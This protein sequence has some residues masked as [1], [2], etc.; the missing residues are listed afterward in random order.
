MSNNRFGAVAQY[1]CKDGY[2][3]HGD[4]ARVCQGDET[5]SGSIPQCIVAHNV[6]KELC[7]PP[8]EVPHATHDGPPGQK[9]FVL[10]TWLQY[11]CEPD[12]VLSNDKVLRAWCVGGV[13]PAWV[14]PNITCTRNRA[15]CF[16]PP[17]IAHASHDS[18]PQQQQFSSGHRLLYT[19]FYGFYA[20]GQIYAVCND[21]GEW[22]GPSMICLPS[23]CPRLFAPLHGRMY[24]DGTDYG[25]VIR[26]HCDTGYKNVGSFERR[27]LADRTWSGQHAR[28]EEMSCAWPGP[29]HNGYLD[30][31]KTTVG[32]IIRFR[33]NVRTKLQGAL[34]AECLKSGKWSENLPT[35]WGQCK[36][37]VL[38]NVSYLDRRIL[39][40]EDHG[41]EIEYYC[42]GGLVPRD[43]PIMK[44]YNGTWSTTAECLPAPCQSGPPHVLNGMRIYM[45]QGHGFRAKYKCFAGFQLTGM[46]GTYL[47][48][49]FGVWTG[50]TP[51]CTE[52]YCPNPG[53][54][55]N[56]KIYKKS[57]E[58][59][60]DFKPYI[61]TI[62]HGNRL[63][64]DCDMG[65]RVD[66]PGGATCVNGQWQPPLG[67]TKCVPATHPP[68]K[69]LWK[70]L[71]NLNTYV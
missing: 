65:F 43:S 22:T 27:C 13:K 47:T 34:E 49:E 9:R 36:V 50:G 53:T 52:F 59:R 26:F 71:P 19:C 32:S 45:G 18:N 48:C 14:G 62:R 16:S 61:S 8:P 38:P 31:Q 30:D 66:G 46:D 5:W 20:K 40:Y 29:L 54:I 7:P 11:K 15:I 64:Y 10:G 63:E 42:R 35:C 2:R 1:F 4:Q 24:G 21:D 57:Q 17:D 41:V 68:F 67:G 3:L 69:K 25:T 12:Y 44:C 28:C 55:E 23:T 51:L 37:P 6:E 56:G 33:C 60:F 58:S 70:P 39:P